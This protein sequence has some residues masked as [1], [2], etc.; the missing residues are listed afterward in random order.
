MDKLL[1]AFDVAEAN[2]A[3]EAAKESDYD[4]DSKKDYPEVH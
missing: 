3:A 1:A 2:K 4:S